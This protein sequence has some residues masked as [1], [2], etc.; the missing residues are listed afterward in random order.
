MFCKQ[1]IYTIR[2]GSARKEL[3]LSLLRCYGSERLFEN[4]GLGVSRRSFSYSFF[5]LLL[6]HSVQWSVSVPFHSSQLSVCYRGAIL[7]IVN[8]SI[9]QTLYNVSSYEAYEFVGINLLTSEI[10]L[11]LIDDI[12]YGNWDDGQTKRKQLKFC[13]H[14]QHLAECLSL[15]AKWHLAIIFFYYMLA[16]WELK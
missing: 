11:G 15:N 7:T 8:W 10:F 2:A 5:L 1:C 13:W 16:L 3:A 6:R 12:Q 4:I 14:F 9:V